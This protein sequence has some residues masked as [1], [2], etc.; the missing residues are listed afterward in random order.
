MLPKISYPGEGAPSQKTLAYAGLF[1]SC[2]I[3]MIMATDAYLSHKQRKLDMKL[4]QAQFD[5]I[6]AGG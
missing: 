6:N 5:K 4:S 2:A 1:V 3:L